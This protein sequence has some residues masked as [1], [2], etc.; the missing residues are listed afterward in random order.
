MGFA[1]SSYREAGNAC[2]FISEKL[3][4]LQQL[5]GRQRKRY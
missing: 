5:L 1:C 4:L 2:G 3:S